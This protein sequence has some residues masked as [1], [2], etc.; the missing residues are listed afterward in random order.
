MSPKHIQVQ[1]DVR[2]PGAPS[3]MVTIYGVDGKIHHLRVGKL[4]GRKPSAVINDYLEK[5]AEEEKAMP[6]LPLT[7]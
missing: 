1:V 6:S 3:L 7:K 4:D 5:L 2:N